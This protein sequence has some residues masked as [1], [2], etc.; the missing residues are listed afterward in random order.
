MSKIQLGVK[1]KILNT[2]EQ[3]MIEDDT[4]GSTGG[5]YIYM[6][7]KKETKRNGSV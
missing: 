2:N 7:S 4:K 5:Y 6:V 3:I 1:G